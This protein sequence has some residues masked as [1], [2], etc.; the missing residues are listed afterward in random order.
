MI[1]VG[2][3]DEKTACSCLDE[4]GV[5]LGLDLLQLKKDGVITE[6]EIVDMNRFNQAKAVK[7]SAINGKSVDLSPTSIKTANQRY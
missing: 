5:A 7:N 3:I 2:R 1:L 6:K 4:D